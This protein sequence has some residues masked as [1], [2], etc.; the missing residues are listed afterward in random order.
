MMKPHSR[1]VVIE[2]VMPP[3]GQH[4]TLTP[5]SVE[6][7]DLHMMVMLGGKERTGRQFEQLF[8]RAG[9][10]LAR[11]VPTRGIYHIIEGRLALSV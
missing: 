3:E 6:V 2:N 1:V 5:L 10:V 11:S 8:S 7:Q 4:S 9:L